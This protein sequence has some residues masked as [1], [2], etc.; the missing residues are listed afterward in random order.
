MSDEKPTCEPVSE[1]DGLGEVSPMLEDVGECYSCCERTRDDDFRVCSRCSR[2]NQC[3]KC[4]ENHEC[5]YGGDD[6]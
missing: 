5:D 6:Y 1:D 2:D 3:V 4:F